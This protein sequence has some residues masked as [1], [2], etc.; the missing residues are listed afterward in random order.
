MKTIANANVP[1]QNLRMQNV[2]VPPTEGSISASPTTMV[3]P[4]GMPVKSQEMDDV[5]EILIRTGGEKT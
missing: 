5:L 4:G 2:M 1:F 3:H